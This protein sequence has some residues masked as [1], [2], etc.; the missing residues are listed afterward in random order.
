LTR[1]DYRRCPFGGKEWK[2][3]VAEGWITLCIN[4]L[5]LALLLKEK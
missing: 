2:R 3:L 5:G 4:S 1:Y